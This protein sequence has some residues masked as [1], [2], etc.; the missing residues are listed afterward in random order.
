VKNGVRRG[1]LVVFAFGATPRKGRFACTEIGVA[2]F[3]T[4]KPVFPFFG[5]KKFEAFLLRRKCSPKFEW[6]EVYQKV[7]HV[8]PVF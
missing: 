3:F 4:N 7:F 5:S 1:R 6:L 8:F 2:A